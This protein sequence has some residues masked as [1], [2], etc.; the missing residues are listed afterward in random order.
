MNRVQLDSLLVCNYP[1]SPPTFLL[2]LPQ[3]STGNHPDMALTHSAVGC[4]V[5]GASWEPPSCLGGPQDPHLGTSAQGDRVLPAGVGGGLTCV[6]RCWGRMR[7]CWRQGAQLLEE[8]EQ[9]LRAWRTIAAHQRWDGHDP[10]GVLTKHRHMA[11]PPR[12]LI[13]GSVRVARLDSW[14]L[15]FVFSV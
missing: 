4:R 11:Q 9:S 15:N 12:P 8:A 10:L 3:G 14:L 6:P 13:L 1:S 5:S 7:E 2:G